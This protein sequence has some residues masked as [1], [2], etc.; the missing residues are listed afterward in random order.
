MSDFETRRGEFLPWTQKTKDTPAQRAHQSE[1]I[2]QYGGEIAPDC[3]VSA[4]ADIYDFSLFLGARSVVCGN[5]LLRSGCLTTGVDCSINS[6]VYLQGN[7]TLGSGVRIGPKASLIASNHGH[8]DI[9]RT[10]LQQPL[11]EKGITVGDDVW[12]GANSVLVDGITVGSHSIIAAGSVVTKPVG[13]YV[14]VG[15]NPARVIKNRIE[16]YFS[17]RLA[18]FF[19][20]ITPQIA[21]LVASHVENGTYKD[22]SV[23]QLS[24]RAGCDAVE[25]LAMFGETDTLFDPDALMQASQNAQPASPDYSVLCAG[26][27]LEVLGAHAKSPYAIPEPLEDWLQNLPWNENAWGAGDRVDC[28]GTALYHNQKYFGQSA[29]IETLFAWLNTQVNSATGL[30]GNDDLHGCINGFYRLTRGTYAQFGRA[31]PLPEKAIDSILAH[32]QNPRFFSGENGTA[33][34]VLD[35][36]HP[37]W[38]CKKQ[39]AHRFDEGRSWA[40]LWI[41]KILE[42]WVEEKGFCFDLMHHENPSLM[43]TEMWLSILYL[44]C[45]YIGIAHLVPYV[46]QGVHRP[47]TA[48]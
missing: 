2:T 21:P 6:Y 24:I 35:V 31:L 1:L 12:I 7:V 13:D 10:I 18:A 17:A 25:I 19:A 45:D 30:W 48:L 14:I 27:A 32:A 11:Q 5:A 37:L 44:L 39:S 3:F 29:Q 8:T 34:D 20:R 33:C 28:L 36:I 16:T 23:N 38:L 41:D 4:L 42:N 26:Y 9:T 22:S 15:G 43:A 47:E 46:P 40:F